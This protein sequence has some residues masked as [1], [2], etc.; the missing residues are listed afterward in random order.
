VINTRIAGEHD[1]PACVRDRARERAVE[2]VGESAV[3]G[4]DGDARAMDRHARGARPEVAPA[5]GLV[6]D[7]SAR[8]FCSGRG[9][10]VGSRRDRDPTP[11]RIDEQ[12]AASPVATALNP[13]VL[14]EVTS[15]SSEEYD[16][17]TKLDAYA[18]IR[19][20][21]DYIIVSHRERRITVHHPADDETWSARVAISGGRVAIASIDAELDV[22]AI[23]RKS[24]VSRD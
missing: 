17:G 13:T 8:V 20:L 7:V 12:H 22:D 10:R 24:G 5:T 2:V 19:S 6:E 4:C 23:Y 9:R 3:G 1:G 15:D 16:T 21:R 18:T 14:L 11:R